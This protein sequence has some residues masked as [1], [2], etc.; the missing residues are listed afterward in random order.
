MKLQILMTW[1]ISS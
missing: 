1:I